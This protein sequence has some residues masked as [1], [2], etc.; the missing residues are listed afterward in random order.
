MSLC[1]YLQGDNKGENTVFITNYK[2]TLKSIFRSPLVLLT[3]GAT[4]IMTYALYDKFSYVFDGYSY[5]L[6]TLRQQLG[7]QITMI[8]NMLFPPFAGI[9]ISAHILSERQNGFGDLLVSSHKSLLSIYLSKLC[10]VGT[11]TLVAGLLFAGGNI[12]NFW[13][14]YYPENYIP[15]GVF[16]PIGKILAVYAGTAAAFIPFMLLCY[17]AMPTFV[18][19]ITNIPA[20]GAVWNVGFYLAGSV[21]TAF[22][23]TDFFLPPDS[24]TR[25]R[26]SF[27]YIENPQFMADMQAGLIKDSIG[28]YSVTLPEALTAYIGWIV[29]SLALLTAAYFILKKRYRT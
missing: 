26:F 13:C 6:P 11:V 21:Y 23:S 20:A 28:R 10:A 17:I 27:D 2:A 29:F 15:D 14:V 8:G 12:V 9:M 24:V 7:N 25:Y 18:C 1:G 4:L 5:D 22:A 3:F 16:L 19:A